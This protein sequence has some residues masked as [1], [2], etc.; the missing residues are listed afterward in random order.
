MIPNKAHR[1]IELLKLKKK[2]RKSSLIVLNLGQKLIINLNR[3]KIQVKPQFSQINDEIKEL[4]SQIE[5]LKKETKEEKE[6]KSTPPKETYQL[7]K[8]FDDALRDTKNRL[9]VISPWISDRVMN[10]RRLN[11][12]E[13]L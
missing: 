12:I 8:V 10:N 7:T 13:K 11:E 1:S 4:H 5:K 2:K 6:K 9:I 3:S